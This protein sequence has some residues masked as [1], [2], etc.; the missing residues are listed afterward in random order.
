MALTTPYERVFYVSDGITAEYSFPF[1]LISR[2]FIH[3]NLKHTDGRIEYDVDV[4]VPLDKTGEIIGV[5]AFN[6]EENKVPKAGT[7]IMI[8]RR[9]PLTQD[10][11]YSK[12][13]QFSAKALDYSFDKLQAQLQELTERIDTSVISTNPFQKPIT[14][15]VLTEKNHGQYLQFDYDKNTLKGGLFFNNN[16]YFGVSS[17]GTTWSYYYNTQ[18][19]D[20]KIT[21]IKTYSDEQNAVLESKIRDDMNAED[22]RL[23]TQITAHANAITT[24]KNDIDELGDDVAEI[25]AKIPESA[26]GSNPLITKQQLLEEEMDI[27]DDLNESVSELQTQIT[28][29]AAEIATKQDQLTAGDNIIISGNIISATGASGSVGFDVIVVQELL[30][31]GEKGIIY[32]VPKDSA[33]PDVY[34]EYVWVTTT[35]TFELIGSTKVDL[36]NYVKNTDYATNTTGGIVKINPYTG[37]NIV[38]GTLMVQRAQND[39]ILSKT[40]KFK[41][42][43]PDNLD[44]AV[45][46]SVTTN[47]ITLTDDEKTA[48]RT[49]LGAVGTTDYGTSIKAGL[50]KGYHASGFSV[51]SVGEAYAVTKTLEQYNTAYDMLFVSKGTLDNIKNDLVKRG[52]TTNTN[53]LTSEEQTAAKEWLG[54][55]NVSS[56]PILTHMFSDHIINDMSWL[57]ADTFSWQSGDVYVAAYNHLASD[58]ESPVKHDVQLYAWGDSLSPAYTTSETPVEGDLIYDKTYTAVGKAVGISETNGGL[59]YNL[60]SGLSGVGATRYESGDIVGAIAEHT[61]TIGDITITYYQAEDGHKI[62][63]PDQED[64]VAALY[65]MTG[66]AWYYLLDTVNK[67]FKLPRTKFGFTGLR[68]SVGGYVAPGLPNITGTLNVYVRFNAA[69]GAFELD[70]AFTG[71]TNAAGLNYTASTNSTFDASR[72]SPVY[73]NGDT[74]QPP[75]TEMYLYFYVG[76]FEQSAIEQTAGINAEMFNSKVDKDNV[77]DIAVSS[78]MLDYTA[79]VNGIALPY[80]ATQRGMVRVTIM[81]A[82]DYV[83]VKVNG[84]TAM[85]AGGSNNNRDTA[86]IPVD[87][88]DVVTIDGT[89]SSSSG[90]FIPFKGV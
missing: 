45:K 51:N 86:L 20:N 28:A 60:D 72:S 53:G 62:C 77:A 76:N 64:N 71:L 65:E 47:T 40:Q 7:I 42:I 12:Q 15:D 9:T 24:N 22:S 19:I 85:Y 63:L 35:S 68:D 49:W 67:Q 54:I 25:Q 78:T 26:S 39:E 36:T 44:L 29:Q 11:D 81:T 61:D 3:V 75:A 21:E 1:V 2:D 16:N 48:A 55:K 17:D 70:P 52:I 57:R 27:R 34:D 32:L 74:V 38:N 6:K 13:I 18:I 87:I 46:T 14:L 56:L 84:I 90:S 59:V 43:V 10:T 30:E 80:T 4:E 89:V 23:Q 31:S 37:I 73:G 82:S 8:E 5:I 79:E 41:P 50:I 33:A 83:Y 58:L 66:V 69:S 88:G